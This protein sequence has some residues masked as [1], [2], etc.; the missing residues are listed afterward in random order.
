MHT[1]DDDATI[2]EALRHARN[3]T[4]VWAGWRIGNAC[5]LMRNLRTRRAMSN[6][7]E[8]QEAMRVINSGE[9]EL[10]SVGATYLVGYVRKRD[11]HI[12]GMLHG[13]DMAEAEGNGDEDRATESYNDSMPELIDSDLIEIEENDMFRPS[14]P[15]T[16]LETPDGMFDND[17]AFDDD[18]VY[19]D[20]PP[21]SCPYLSLS[22]P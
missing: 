21:L 20:M 2:V 11:D 1:N 22:V 19:D 7:A 12:N 16:V 5:V 18:D 13:S 17:E 10:G 4:E 3:T 9:S 8:Q 14:S 6:A 15:T